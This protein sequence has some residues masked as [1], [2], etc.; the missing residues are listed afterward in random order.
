MSAGC[1]TMWA[2]NPATLPLHYKVSQDSFPQQNLCLQCE[3]LSSSLIFPSHF[4]ETV[5]CQETD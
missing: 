3:R 5:F 1:Q 4:R 2:V